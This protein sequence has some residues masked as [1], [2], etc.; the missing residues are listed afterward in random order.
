MAKSTFR[1]RLVP[2]LIFENFDGAGS[3][4]PEARL[5][6]A[7]DHPPPIIRTVS[8]TGSRDDLV[9]RPDSKRRHIG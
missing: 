4:V 9:F 3:R 6:I 2:L 1:P 8:P 5:R 7:V